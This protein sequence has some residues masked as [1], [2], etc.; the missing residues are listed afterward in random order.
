MFELIQAKGN[1]KKTTF[2]WAKPVVASL[3]GINTDNLRPILA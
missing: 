2:L 1:T 3:F